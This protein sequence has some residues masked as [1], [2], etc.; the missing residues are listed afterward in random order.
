MFLKIYKPADPIPTPVVKLIGRMMLALDDY[1]WRLEVN[2]PH[3]S[4]N[5]ATSS[6][7]DDE[8][9]YW[10]RVRQAHY[11]VAFADESMTYPYGFITY[12]SEGRLKLDRYAKYISKM[13]NLVAIYHLFVDQDARRQHV[14]SALLDE[15]Y[16]YARAKR[17]KNVVLRCINY[18][19]LAKTFYEKN[20]YTA[21]DQW[22]ILDRKKA[23]NKTMTDWVETRYKSRDLKAKVI[24]LFKTRMREDAKIF[25]PLENYIEEAADNFNRELE[26]NR[27]GKLYYYP[28]LDIYSY[29]YPGEETGKE[30]HVSAIL[31]E[32]NTWLKPQ[33]KLAMEELSDQFP[34]S[35]GYY[36]FCSMGET[37]DRIL[38]TC[39]YTPYSLT[40]RK[41][42]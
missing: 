28:K 36:S 30:I 18:N 37:E 24:K 21:I 11:V 2:S 15:C 19:T 40:Y 23:L 3:G 17:I 5:F 10:K 41:S 39:G 26:T 29:L 31:C 16:K 34:S 27:D 42:I 13:D 33:F 20:K 7:T 4:N 38:R 22:F 6:I 1:H 35:K 8:V 25:Y 32:K 14:G 12:T 9:L